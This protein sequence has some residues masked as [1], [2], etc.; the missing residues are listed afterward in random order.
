MAASRLNG[1]GAVPRASRYT[2]VSLEGRDVRAM[3]APGSQRAR[4]RVTKAAKR[5]V[6]D[7]KIEGYFL[8]P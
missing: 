5:K 2:L 3:M 4:R 7:G 6:A 8:V 1:E